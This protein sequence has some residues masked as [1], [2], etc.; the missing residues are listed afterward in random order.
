MVQGLQED[1]GDK[2]ITRREGKV[3][4]LLCPLED[5]V[6]VTRGEHF[7]WPSWTVDDWRAA[8]ALWVIWV[9]SDHAGCLRE[10]EEGRDA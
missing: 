8:L 3:S 4:L 10:V 9:V 5:S 1:E 6:R 2:D 7:R